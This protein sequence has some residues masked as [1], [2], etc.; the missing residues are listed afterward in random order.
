MQESAQ[1]LSRN[2]LPDASGHGWAAAAWMFKAVAEAHGW[3]YRHSDEIVD[4]AR[5]AQQKTDDPRVHDLRV[6][7]DMLLTFSG[8]RNRYLQADD[9][10]ELLDRMA[11]LLDILEP[12]TQTTSNP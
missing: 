1:L 8:T 2:K 10:S 9:V 3:Q 5:R 12:L 4:I 7:A 6:S 11:T